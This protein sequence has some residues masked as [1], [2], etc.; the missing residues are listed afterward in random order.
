MKPL[1]KEDVIEE[2]DHITVSD[3]VSA[4]EWLKSKIHKSY[5]MQDAHF[6]EALINTAF[7]IGDKDVQ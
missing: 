4:K 2:F 5:E 6:I 3:M 7:D 1:T